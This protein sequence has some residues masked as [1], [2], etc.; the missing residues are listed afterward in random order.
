MSG[1]SKSSAQH[2]KVNAAPNP[3]AKEEL[4]LL[5]RL[6]GGLEGQKP[7]ST[8]NG[9]RVNLFATD[10]EEEISRP[11]QNWPRS[12]ESS[13]SLEISLQVPAAKETTFWP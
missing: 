8:D 12:W 10:E 2:T 5:A 13:H 7:G 4:N 6:M 1:A 9:F 3:L 11:M